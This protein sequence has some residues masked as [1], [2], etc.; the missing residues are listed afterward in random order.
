MPISLKAGMGGGA[1]SQKMPAIKASIALLDA[2]PG[3]RN[4]TVPDGVT[5]IRAFVVGGGGGGNLSSSNGRGGGGGGYSEKTIDVTPGQVFSY[6]VGAAGIPA[7]STSIGGTQGG[8]SSFGGLITATGG[9]GVTSAANGVGGGGSGGDVNTSGGA[10]YGTDG[11]GPTGA[12]GGAGH[13]YGNGAAAG[14]YR[15]GGFL[16][17]GAGLID[18]WKLGIPAG[19]MNYGIG[20]VYA[21]QNVSFVPG[22]GGGGSSGVD[23]GIGG[24]GGNGGSY[25]GTGLVGI[26]V[27]V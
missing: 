3:T 10:G 20:S 23:A 1:I 4:W 11:N 14:M 9:T 13:A 18:G 27:V 6:T 12:G 24:G 8:S 22:L 25:G 5:R 16:D 15:G 17:R 21:N 19:L 26:E 7:Q 2:Q